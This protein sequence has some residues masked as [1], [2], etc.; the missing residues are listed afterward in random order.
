G[1][2][3]RSV[4]LPG[5]EFLGNLVAI[6]YYYLKTRALR[7][8][9]RFIRQLEQEGLIVWSKL[10]RE[11]QQAL[12]EAFEQAL[13]LGAS[14]QLPYGAEIFGKLSPRAQAAFPA[15]ATDRFAAQGKALGKSD[16]EIIDALEAEAKATRL[17]GDV[18]EEKLLNPSEVDEVRDAPN[19]P[20]VTNVDTTVGNS[21]LLGQ[22]LT[23]A[24]HPNPSVRLPGER[25]Q[26]HHIIPSNE[27]PEE[28]R[29]LLRK[30]DLDING[31]F[32]GVWLPTGKQAS[33][34]TGAF[35]HEFLTSKQEYFSR[36]TAILLK[37][38]PLTREQVI[39]KLLAIREYLDNGKLPP[40]KL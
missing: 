10:A 38:P 27:G 26:A 1:R 22:N 20:Y 7:S 36:L 28:L 37:E 29:L 34:P 16:Q 15:E 30:H 25:F 40:P 23:A 3:L 24:G 4:G 33:N 32:N 18:D 39:K 11:E 9:D 13:K 6:T 14:K 2:K 31:E 12:Q 21:R 5:G 17:S 35:K 8:F 19:I